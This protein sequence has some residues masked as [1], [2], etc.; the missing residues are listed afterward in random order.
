MLSYVSL[1][2]YTES[3]NLCVSGMILGYLFRKTLPFPSIP[4]PV[5]EWV[6]WEADSQPE[7][8]M[9]ACCP[10]DQRL[11]KKAGSAEREDGLRCSSCQG[12]A[13]DSL[14]SATGPGRRIAWAK[15]GGLGEARPGGLTAEGCLPAA[16]AQPSFLSGDGGASQR[17]SPCTAVCVSR[18]QHELTALVI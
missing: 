3:L 7:T 17:L 6:F 5:V 14:R 9:A 2:L 4:F 10:W 15:A 1:L 12:E 16:G 13:W 18:E 11:G 8:S